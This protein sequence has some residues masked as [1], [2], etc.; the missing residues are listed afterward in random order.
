MDPGDG[1]S[2]LPPGQ[3]KLCRACYQP[4]SAGAKFCPSCGANQYPTM[5]L[6][7]RM[8]HAAL[9]WPPVRNAIIFYLIYLATV[10]PV[11]WLPEEDIE[12]LVGTV[13]GLLLHAVRQAFGECDH[14]LEGGLE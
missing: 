11:I 3:I 2:G 10:V 4:I 5:E 1:S 12:G 8:E 13:Q 7:Q 9:G 14:A 6:E